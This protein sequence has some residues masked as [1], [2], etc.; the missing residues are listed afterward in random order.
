MR[1]LRLAV[2]SLACL[3]STVLRAQ[4][5]AQIGNCPF[6]R[7]LVEPDV[8]QAS[9][10]K[11]ETTL[12]VRMA[13]VAVPV[14]QNI[15]TSTQPN[16][17]CAM[18]PMDLRQYTWPS[19][20]SP[21]G[22]SGFPGPTFRLRKAASRQT[23]GDSLA[24]HLIN[25]LP[26]A[27]ND[28][29]DADCDCSKPQN[30][31]RC[32][33]RADV[34]PACF[35]G[36]NNTNLHFHGTHVSPQPPQD[37]VL[38]ELRPKG[39][40]PDSAGTHHHG[41]V[42]SGR[43]D[44]ALDPFRFTQ[45][46]GTHWYHPHKH[47]STALQVGNGMAGALIIE[48]KFDDDL[49][50]LFG[51]KL[52][53]HLMV[54]QLIHP[55]NFNVAV[56]LATQPLINGQPSPVV[57]MYPGEINRFRFIAA[58]IQADGA[59]T[60]DFNSPDDDAVEVKQIAMDGIQFAPENY[61]RQPALNEKLEFDM[62]PGNRADFL[63]KAPMQPGLYD[64]TYDLR[65]PDPT[66]RGNNSNDTDLKNVIEFLAPGDA[67]PRLFRIRVTACGDPNAC[68][69]MAFPKVS[70]FPKMPDFLA[71][72]PAQAVT[73]R[74]S[75]FF[76]LKDPQGSV[77]PPNKIPSQPSLFSINLRQGETRQFNPDCDD[78]TMRI[79]DVQEWTILNTSSRVPIKPLHVFHIH[80]NAFQVIHNPIR[81]K[82]DNPP[83]VW[84]DSLLLPDV[85]QGP[86]VIRQH[87][88]DFTGGFVLH[89]HFLGHEDRG[90]MLGVQTVCPDNPTKYGKPGLTGA[91]DCSAPALIDAMPPCS[92]EP[93]KTRAVHH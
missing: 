91:D 34:F 57:D 1:A 78:I 17:Q 18:T 38:L 56:Q 84:Q 22:L 50:A 8:I 58:T 4:T 65:V 15:G 20:I 75:L 39:S 24:V 49:R 92:P 33:L 69:P 3:L 12:T 28:V 44:Y 40:P 16:Y 90:M 81:P 52:K 32:C 83:W 36:D 86:V 59:I 31:A 30:L 21:S 23:I 60:M 67:E 41:T 45:P 76:E 68:P 80:T 53:E 61:E 37:Y 19:P 74:R 25:E 27:P 64:V 29:C 55:L 5:P 82:M 73:L 9:G 66:T 43:Y 72:I 7:P 77:L 79:G 70:D 62:A 35:H 13:T 2:F 51:G 71:D 85:T 11:L 63:V 10:G 89:C 6:D 46:E 93:T 48:G 26:I 47:G 14:W 54:V 88:N 42:A 87:F